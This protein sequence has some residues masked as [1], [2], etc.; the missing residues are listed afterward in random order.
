MPGG[1]INNWI[2]KVIKIDQIED[3]SAAVVLSLPCK[4]FVGSG[5]IDTKS[6]WLKK[7]SKEWR[8]TIPYD[9]RRF[10]ELAKLDKGQFVVASAVLLE[11][12]AFK[13]GQIEIFCVSQQIGD[14]PLTKRLD[15]KG[16]LFITDLTYIV[17]L[18]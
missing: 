11:V 9:D 8:A 17:A 12:G 16:E 13:P 1:K 6:S 18:N 4:S 3:G 7:G 14:H 5:Q 15:L 2:F 10:R